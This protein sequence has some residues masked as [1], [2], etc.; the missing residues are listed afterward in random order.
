MIKDLLEIKKFI[1][2]EAEKLGDKVKFGKIENDKMFATLVRE[3]GKKDK[4]YWLLDLVNGGLKSVWY[5]QQ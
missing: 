3:S 2:R 4:V 1:R 5:Y